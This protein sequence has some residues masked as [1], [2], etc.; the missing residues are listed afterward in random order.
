[1]CNYNFCC[2]YWIELK[3]ASSARGSRKKFLSC[4]KKLFD[5]DCSCESRCINKGNCCQD[6]QHY[7]N[8]YL[9][10]YNDQENVKSHKNNKIP[11]QPK[12]QQ[13]KYQS[14]KKNIPSINPNFNNKISI[15]KKKLKKI[16]IKELFGK[17]FTKFNDKKNKTKKDEINLLKNIEKIYLKDL[18]KKNFKIL[19]PENNMIKD[20][21]SM[22]SM[23]LK[24]NVSINSL[25]NNENTEILN[26]DS[27]MINSNNTNNSSKSFILSYNNV[28]SDKSSEDL[29][30]IINNGMISLANEYDQQKRS[31]LASR[32]LDIDKHYKID[33]PQEFENDDANK[34]FEFSPLSILKSHSDVKE[35]VKKGYLESNN[36]GLVQDNDLAFNSNNRGP[37]SNISDESQGFNKDIDYNPSQNIDLN[38][39]NKIIPNNDINITKVKSVNTDAKANMDKYKGLNGIT[40]SLILGEGNKIQDN[41][42]VNNIIKVHNSF[43]IAKKLLLNGK[44]N[45]NFNISKSGINPSIINWLNNS[46]QSN[47]TG[48]LENFKNHASSAP[49]TI[50]IINASKMTKLEERQV[51]IKKLCNV[52]ENNKCKNCKKNTMKLIDYSCE[53]QQGFY[54]NEELDQCE[55]K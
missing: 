45:P 48:N 6:F 15:T 1:M 4:G 16:I 7:C 17:N 14:P 29:K 39:S 30:S 47:N 52:C 54:Y 41:Q 53:C 19:S 36:S 35:L 51:C 42:V 26:Q 11:S 8:N 27:S 37:K 2:L 50:I 25:S 31:V 24:G 18:V 23:Y 46:S 49:S 13:E 10:I 32:K 34:P 21:N 22:L 3:L 28:N 5:A 40:R 55:S 38:I 20:E 9:R 33:H 43:I 44:F 12:K